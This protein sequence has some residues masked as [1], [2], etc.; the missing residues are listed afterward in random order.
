MR[1][2]SLLHVAGPIGAGKT[3]F[4]ERLLEA[5]I[6][7]A[8]CI[9]GERDAKLRK[10]QES[11]PRSH[12]E[13][14]RYRRAGAAAVALYRFGVPDTDAFFVSSVM[15]NY[16]EVAIVEGDYPLELVD[17]SVL[18]RHPRNQGGR[19]CNADSVIPPLC[20]S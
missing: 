5:E 14:C 19:C 2:R 12:A 1:S 20:I 11:N 9:R 8:I 4:I 13:L 17:L 7:F 3:T 6:A 10:E 16:S 15:Q 18:S